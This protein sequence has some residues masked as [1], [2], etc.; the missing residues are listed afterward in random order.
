MVR[1]ANWGI[2]I[3]WV[4][5]MSGSALGGVHNKSVN[6]FSDLTSIKIRGLSLVC[7]KGTTQGEHPILYKL[8]TVNTTQLPLHCDVPYHMC[9]LFI[10]VPIIK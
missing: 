6:G 2:V 7:L 5:I 3:P 4:T 9:S 1:L 8:A 10:Y